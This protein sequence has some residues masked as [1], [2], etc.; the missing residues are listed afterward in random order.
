VQDE[1]GGNAHGDLRRGLTSDIQS[2]RGSHLLESLSGNSLVQQVREGGLHSTPT[3]Y[4]PDIGREGIGLKDPAEAFIVIPMATGHQNHVAPGVERS[5]GEGVLEAH[6]QDP[7][8]F[9]ESL[10]RGELRPIVQ[11]RDSVAQE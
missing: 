9:R 3:P 7:L 11:Y 8:R 10:S 5:L 1:L 2:D 6:G 4:H